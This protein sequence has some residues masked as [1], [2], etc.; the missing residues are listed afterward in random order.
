MN[1]RQPA[2]T[3]YVYFRADTTRSEEVLRSFSQHRDRLARPPGSLQLARRSD[4]PA[5][6]VT[7]MEIYARQAGEQTAELLERIEQSARDSGLTALA[8]G[9][10]HVETFIAVPD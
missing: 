5:D 7:W 4:D 1:D 9:G 8:T 10:R 6:A 3:I 2:V